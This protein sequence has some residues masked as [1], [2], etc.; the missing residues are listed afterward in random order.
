VL[1]G[2]FFVDG[3]VE[4]MPK[5]VEVEQKR[6]EI[7][8]A[9]AATFA[10]SG[11]RTSLERVAARAGMGKSSLYHYFP[12]REALF[13]TLVDDLLRHEAGLFESMLST[14]GTP[15]ERLHQLLESLAALFGEWR[16]VGPLVLD[17]L[18]TPHGRRRLKEM[19]RAA[20]GALATLI[21]EGQQMGVFREG[22]PPVLSTLVLA[23][24]DGL[25]LQELVDPGVA[26]GKAVE[27]AMRAAVS[28]LLTGRK[29]Q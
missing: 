25:L 5:V 7:L 13:N 12:T 4:K 23:V 29:S 22:S 28:G 21:R 3:V 20:R 8:A 6:R 16:Q 17:F 26:S 27:T 18:S 10:R 24:M 19:L 15:N 1:C 11:H 9:A 14:P 2:I